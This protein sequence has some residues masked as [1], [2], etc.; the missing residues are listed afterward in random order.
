M[1][2]SLSI[3]AHRKECPTDEQFVHQVRLQLISREME[4]LR[5]P[6]VPPQFYFKA[7]QAKIDDVKGAISP[8]FKNDGELLVLIR[9]LAHVSM[10]DLL[11]YSF[12]GTYTSP[13]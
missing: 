7:L 5:Q 12:L 4:T 10:T 8:E 3:L 13:S 6:S 11:E 9:L 1:E 2:E